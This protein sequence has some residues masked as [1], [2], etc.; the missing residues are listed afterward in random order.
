VQARDALA[1][2]GQGTAEHVAA[3]V[4]MAEF[5]VRRYWPQIN[6]VAAVLAQA[7]LD[8]AVVSR[9]TGAPYTRA[10][11]S[12]RWLA[13]PPIPPVTEPRRAFTCVG[14]TALAGERP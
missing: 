8:F 6:V 7:D 4:P 13:M 5:M 2:I 11:A 12:S 1:L 14:K 10:T 9:L 3:L